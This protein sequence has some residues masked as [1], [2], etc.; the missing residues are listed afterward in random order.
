[1]TD[2]VTNRF[3]PLFEPKTVAVIGASARGMTF[4][5]IFM[6][7]IREFGFKGA[8]YPIHP[9]A[10]NI[11][12]LPAYRSLGDTPE[13]VD[14]A[15]IA[16]PGAQIPPML[17]AARGR[18]RYAQVISSGFGEVDEGR[19]LQAELAAA[20]RE[21]GMRLIGPN[22]LGMYSH[23]GGIVFSETWPEAAGHV[24]AIS[25][26]GGIGTDTVRRG[27]TR[28]IRYSGVVT[29]GNCA[30]LEPADF[31]EFY[32][33]DA[34]TRVIGMYIESAGDGRRL[35]ELLRAAQGRKPVVILKGGRTRLGTMAAASH[36]G[37]LAGDDRAW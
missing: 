24:G 26:S 3:K 10:D 36:T 27:I 16:V 29:I 14:Y 5:N 2:S 34:E 13:P 11:D 12:G 35:F 18:V 15:F 21:G 28:G 31:V 33:A 30:D 23:R 32:L 37:S 4:P 22:C 9:S 20:A 1:M 7:R 19:A 25:Q 6:R 8:I 17:R